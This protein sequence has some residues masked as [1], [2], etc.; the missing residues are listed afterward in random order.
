MALGAGDYSAIQLS[1]KRES[2]FGTAPSGNYKTLNLLS[3]GLAGNPGTVR[4]EEARSDR[5]PSQRKR[6]SLDGGGAF[7][8]DLRFGAQFEA[9]LE[10]GLCNAFG[11]VLAISSTGIT[12]TASD[13]SLNGTA[14][15]G[16]ILP[17]QII[18]IG[19]A[20]TGG[21]NGY[22]RV[23]SATA[24]KVIVSWLTITDE[25]AGA[26][27]TITGSA[28]VPGSTKLSRTYQR[29][30]S[31]FSTEQYQAYRGQLANTLGMMFGFRELIKVD[32]GLMGLMPDART[33]TPVASGYDAVDAG[34]VLDVSNNM[35]LH[36]YDGTLS[37]NIR[38]VN[39]DWNNNMEYVPVA[40]TPSPDD[41]SLGDVS[42]GGQYEVYV[43]D[44]ADLLDDAYADTPVALSWSVQPAAGGAYFFTLPRV[45]FNQP[46]DSPKSAKRGPCVLTLD[47]EAEPDDNG[48]IFVVSKHA[49]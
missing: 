31:D 2:T 43:L 39:F 36:R 26:T 8:F 15:F 41:I 32:V 22:A 48:Q 35:S 28:L 20:G 25:A 11:S 6:V 24:N 9:F 44:A 13:N 40:Q 14:L 37:G 21:N 16:A 5:M 30:H 18:L 7:S 45:K 47:W 42:L 19:G 4:S 23:V 12:F 1:S 10:E 29:Y 17:N 38:K 27:V 3:E 46:G 49:A 34:E 33:G